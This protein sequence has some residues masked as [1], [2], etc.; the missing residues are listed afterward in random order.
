MILAPTGTRIRDLYGCSLYVDG[1]LSTFHLIIFLLSIFDCPLAHCT[2]RGNWQYCAGVGADPREDRYFNIVKQGRNYD[3]DAAFVRLWLPELAHLP[4]DALLDVRMFTKRI[5]ETHQITESLYPM[6]VCTLQHTGYK[7][8]AD[9]GAVSAGGSGTS[10]SSSSSSS[11]GGKS[12]SS[13]PRMKTPNHGGVPGNNRMI[14]MNALVKQ[15]TS[16][17]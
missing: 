2:P 8:E 17:K 9:H 1:L 16:K 4:T 14:D 10:S 13:K 7:G 15:H 5:R 6:P 3:P 11:S 12:S